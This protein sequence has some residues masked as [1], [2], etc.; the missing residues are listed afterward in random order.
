M[1]PLMEESVEV[2]KCNKCVS[3]ISGGQSGHTVQIDCD[4]IL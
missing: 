3:G 2:Q 4:I 1:N